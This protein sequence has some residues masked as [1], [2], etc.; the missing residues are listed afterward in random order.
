RVSRAKVSVDDRVIGRIDIYKRGKLP[1]L[2]GG[3]GLYIKAYVDGLSTTSI[4]ANRSLRKSLEGRSVDDLFNQLGQLD[5]IKAASL[6]VSDRKNPR[7]LVRAIEVAQ[8]KV[9]KKNGVVVDDEFIDK[10]DSLFIG[11]KLQE[12][13]VDDIIKDRVH[14]RINIGFEKEVEA[15]VK[16][17]LSW[18]SQAMSSLG[19]KQWRLYFLGKETKEESTK[20][21]IRAER[22]YVK[23]QMTWFKRDERIIWFDATSATLID[24]VEMLVKRWYKDDENAKKN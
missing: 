10:P 4:P 19:Y 21:W 11:L 5:P 2:E 3:T 15:L 12:D 9:K 7:R 17:G 8:W 1:I 13:I 18:D 16:G 23:R 14:N 22:A 20:A 24:D 6:N